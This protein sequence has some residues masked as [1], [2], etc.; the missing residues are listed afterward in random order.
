MVYVEARSA[1]DLRR[2]L[3]AAGVEGA[4]AVPERALLL[5]Q[6][7]GP[8]TITQSVVDVDASATDTYLHLVAE[9]RPLAE[10]LF[11]EVEPM[12]YRK[13]GYLQDQRVRYF[14]S[15]PARF[16]TPEEVR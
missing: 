10:V 11:P 16:A 3:E 13:W 8:T 12:P 6:S 15:G 2:A 4:V 14:P 7:R 9:E 5:A 1:D